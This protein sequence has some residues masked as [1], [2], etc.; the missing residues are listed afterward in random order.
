MPIRSGRQL[1][2]DF[3]RLA[4]LALAYWLAARLSL[5]LALVHGQVTP[6]WPPTGIALVAFLLMG[7]RAWPAVAVAAFA[8][9]LPLGPSPLGA[10]IIAAGNTLAPLVAAELLKRVGFH[11]ELDRLEDAMAIIGIGALGGMAISAT[12]GSSVLLLSGDI[13]GTEFWPA[14]AVW[15]TGD[16]MGVLLVAPLLLSLLA[17]PSSPALTWRQGLELAGLLGGTAIVTYFLFQNRLDLEYLVLPLIMVAAWRFHLRG[18]APAALIASGVAIWSAINGTG[19]FAGETL[20]EK[21]VTLQVFNVSVALASFL[22]ALFVDTRERKEEMSRLYASAQEASDAKTG[23]LHMAAHELRT[24]ITVLTGY[25]AMLSDGT[26][27][28]VPDGWKKTLDILVG[29][30]WELNRIVA[31]LLEASRIEANALPRNV[32]EIDLRTVIQDAR[33]RALPR[34]QLLGAEIATRMTANP[35]AVEADAVQLG[36]IL[37]NLINNGLTYTLQPPRVSITAS[38]EGDRA[39]VRVADNG[40]GISESERE[41]VFERFHRS[42]EPAFR[43]VPGTGLGLYISRQLAEGHGGSLVIES[44]SPSGTTFALALPL[45]RRASTPVVPVVTVAGHPSEASPI[46]VATPTEALTRS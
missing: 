16:A 18:A 27:G 46:Q 15:W 17:R 11:P 29:K 32:G 20:F 33:E 25:L 37:D 12:V 1:V 22:L 28:A 30:T 35:V 19:P 36:R 23:F 21:M 45:S 42:N 34:A 3:W 14:W 44:S 5:N 13:P 41:R 7:R 40:A 38:E 2:R 10:A 6:I 26:L 43:S 24:P 4:L 31:D 39:V 9:N 8:V